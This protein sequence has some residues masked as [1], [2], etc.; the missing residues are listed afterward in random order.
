MSFTLHTRIH[1]PLMNNWGCL[2]G[3]SLVSLE[4]QMASVKG[5][6][7]R[8]PHPLVFPSV[9]APMLLHDCTIESVCQH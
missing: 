3:L 4:M 1:T 8:R 5:D 7:C 2:I 9:T 6:D